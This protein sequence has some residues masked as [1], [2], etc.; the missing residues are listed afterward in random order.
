MAQTLFITSP[1][2]GYRIAAEKDDEIP[3]ATIRIIDAGDATVQEFKCWAYKVYNFGAHSTEIIDSFIAG[4][5][6]GHEVA[7]SPL[8]GPGAVLIAPR[9]QE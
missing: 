1:Y 3:A 8:I 6:D 2:R 5:T 4:N 9:E 7:A